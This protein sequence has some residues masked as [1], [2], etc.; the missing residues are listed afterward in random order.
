MSKEEKAKTVED[1][2][3]RLIKT[4]FGNGNGEKL[5]DMWQDVY[6]DLA[7]YIPGMDPQ[8]VAYREGGRAFYIFIKQVMRHDG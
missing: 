4:V 2:Y 7:S 6:G 3:Q 5:L 8:E 1:E